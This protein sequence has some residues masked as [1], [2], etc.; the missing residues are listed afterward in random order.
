[1]KEINADVRTDTLLTLADI[2]THI[3]EASAQFHREVGKAMQLLM[4]DLRHNT[5]QVE[6]KGIPPK[7]FA[8]AMKK[9]AHDYDNDEEGMHSMMDALMCQALA[10]LGYE[11]GVKVF[12]DAPKWY[13]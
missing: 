8:E 13:A 7:T 10:V 4:E 5:K 12:E 9:I 1:M 11:E 2:I 3:D 6:P